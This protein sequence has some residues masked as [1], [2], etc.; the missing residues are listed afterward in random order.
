MTGRRSITGVAWGSTTD[1]CACTTIAV[2][3]FPLP[4][5]QLA[6]SSLP[7]AAC[8]KQLKVHQPLSA[9]TKLS[10]MGMKRRIQ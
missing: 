8:A 7:E 4:P 6:W 3:W 5:W 1:G 2:G 9:S 10:T